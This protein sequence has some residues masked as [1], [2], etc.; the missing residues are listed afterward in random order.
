[1]W[2]LESVPLW[3]GGVVALPVIM[4]GCWLHL[5]L[6]LRQSWA[7][8]AQSTRA[9]LC[10]LVFWPLSDNSCSQLMLFVYCI[11]RKIYFVLSYEYHLVQNLLM[12]LK[13]V[14]MTPFAGSSPSSL[15]SLRPGVVFVYA[16]VN[17][18]IIGWDNG[19]SPF[20]CNMGLLLI[21]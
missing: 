21:G 19:L 5:G 12:S 18:V 4:V 6:S 11:R 9:P 16:S 14:P 13:N 15:N 8:S 20:W 17:C 2:Y 3:G 1:M 10:L 7:Q